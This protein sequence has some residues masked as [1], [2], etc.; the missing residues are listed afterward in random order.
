MVSVCIMVIILIKH[1]INFTL[2]STGDYSRSALLAN[3]V[4]AKT[5][6]PI[7]YD[8]VMATDQKDA[9]GWIPLHS[10]LHSVRI[11]SIN[12]SIFSHK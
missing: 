7:S 9:L 12:D 3:E 5:P 4:T 11:Y 6:L 10:L 2:W 1:R 8:D